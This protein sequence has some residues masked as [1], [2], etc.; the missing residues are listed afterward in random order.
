MEYSVVP[1]ALAS[2][3]K[4]HRG[5][6]IPEMEGQAAMARENV[7]GVGGSLESGTGYDTG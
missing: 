3:A 2:A 5:R 1:L 7:V 4:L 6:E